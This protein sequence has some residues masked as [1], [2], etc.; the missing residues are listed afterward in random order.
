MYKEVVAILGDVLGEHGG[1]L[2]RR[3]RDC[4]R[5]V[6]YVSALPDSWGVVFKSG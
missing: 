2:H 4:V 1:R 3:R 5:A 6:L